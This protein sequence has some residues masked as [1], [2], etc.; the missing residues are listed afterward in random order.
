MK[1]TW[2]A[3]KTVTIT[4]DHQ[5]IAIASLPE[6]IQF[7]F[8]TYD[9]FKQ[10]HNDILYEYEKIKAA[11]NVKFSEIVRKIKILNDSKKESTT[12]EIL[13]KIKEKGNPNKSKSQGETHD[14]SETEVL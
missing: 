13:K 6:D 4:V 1:K 9:L 2:K 12:E 11:M 10:E 14:N 5:T 3:E 8:E 7:D